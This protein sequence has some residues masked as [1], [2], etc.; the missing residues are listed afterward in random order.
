MEGIQLIRLADVLSVVSFRNALGVSPRSI[1]VKGKDF[2]SVE[3]VLFNG[4]TSPEFVVYS[5]TELVAEVPEDIT[6]AII[7]DVMVLSS[8]LTLTDRS[9]VELTFGQR[10]RKVTGILRLMQ[11]FI[12][13]LLRRKGSNIFH[14][15]SGGGIQTRIGGVIT[16]QAAA[17]IAVAIS[18][19]KQYLINIQTAERSIP[20]SERLLSAEI[21]TLNV[22]ARNTTIMVTILLTSHS[23]ETGASLISM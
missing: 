20:P 14:P 19:T 18:T 7:T 9:L 13:L 17:D 2:T 5:D 12:R 15:R 22:D 21:K 16:R 11:T 8:G 10:P 3:T 6:D 4:Y 23:G 1:I